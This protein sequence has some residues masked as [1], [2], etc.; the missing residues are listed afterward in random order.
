MHPAFRDATLFTSFQIY[1]WTGPAA[2]HQKPNPC[3]C[4]ASTPVP[5]F[6]AP[7]SSQDP[8]RAALTY[9][10]SGQRGDG[11]PGCIQGALLPLAP[12]GFLLPGIFP[13]ARPAGSCAE[14]FLPAVFLGIN[15]A[16]EI[17]LREQNPNWPPLLVSHW[18]VPQRSR[19]SSFH[20]LPIL[21]SVEGRRAVI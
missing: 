21:A 14:T 19:S 20:A 8:L 6:Q 11:T 4:I 18:E 2:S 9:R 17:C 3:A 16:R 7:C 13:P 12:S 15:A 5:T 1:Q 10:L